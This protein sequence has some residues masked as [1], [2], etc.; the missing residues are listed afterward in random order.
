M[1]VL[2]SSKRGFLGDDQILPW[3][4]SI[5]LPGAKGRAAIDN[6]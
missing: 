2:D 4:K 5:G 3:W 6:L 1:F